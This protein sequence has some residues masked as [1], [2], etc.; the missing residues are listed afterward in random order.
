MK[1]LRRTLTIRLILGL[2]VIL[3][4][5]EAM[6]F[7]FLRQQIVA[8]YDEG[9]LETARLLASAVHVENDDG[10]LEM[11]LGE[12]PVPGFGTAAPTDY[13]EIWHGATPLYRSASLGAHDLPRSELRNDAP[14][15]DDADLPDGRPGRRVSFVFSPTP[16]PGI[17]AP[18][19][20]LSLTLIREREALHARLRDV[21]LALGG[22]G[23]MLLLLMPVVVA[24]GARTGLSRLLALVRDVDAIDVASLDRR[25]PTADLPVELIPVATRMNHL[26]DRLQQ[27]LIR[28]RRFSDDV[29]HQLRTPIAELRALADVALA[30]AARD[31]A[32]YRQVFED[33]RTIAVQME[34]LAV[35]LLTIARS[36][37][38]TKIDATV[39]DA[40]L[41]SARPLFGARRTRGRSR[42]AAVDLRRRQ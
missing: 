36:G 42:A 29:A 22:L 32:P 30:G 15:T 20:T 28:E 19:M 3:L 26:L 34:R 33:V 2:T 18:A 38:A 23:L 1:S 11:E 5:T 31:D 25:L 37:G 12:V 40:A 24:R 13:F 41:L 9:L 21:S 6:L 35:G 8:S 14:L 10:S 16:E 27:G 17:T 39:V 4:A 7:F